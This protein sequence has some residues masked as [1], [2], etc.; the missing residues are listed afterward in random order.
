MIEC[1]T[2]EERRALAPFYRKSGDV[3]ARSALEGH[4]GRCFASDDGASALVIARGF[5]FPAGRARESFFQETAGELPPG[6][7]TVSGTAAW[8]QIAY[9]Y[10]AVIRMTRYDMQNPPA[11]SEEALRA[12]AVPPEGFQLRWGDEETA[13]QALENAWSED[14][15]TFYPDAAACARD[16]LTVGAYWQGKL[17][18][19]C[20]AYARTA[21][22]V[23]I[24]IDTHPDFRRRGLALCCGA[25]MLLLCRQRGLRPHWDAMTKK[26]ARLAC[27]LGFLPG[28][29]YPVACRE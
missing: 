12:L 24:E 17:V 22:A 9:R 20:G 21:D 25:Q 27:R 28:R 13:K 8:R 19:G 29:A 3:M 18:S 14:L 11:F 2:A 15:C 6:F 26:S 23:E 16:G 5:V 10:G 1:R 7:L 4:C